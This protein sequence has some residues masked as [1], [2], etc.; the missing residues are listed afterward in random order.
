MHAHILS[1]ILPSTCNASV[2]WNFVSTVVE[3]FSVSCAQKYMLVCSNLWIAIFTST[4]TVVIL[5]I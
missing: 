2:H 1:L 3:R 4:K 5:L